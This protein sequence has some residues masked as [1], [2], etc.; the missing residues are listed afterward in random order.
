MAAK[1]Q[2]DFTS[3]SHLLTT[4]LGKILLRWHTLSPVDGSKPVFTPTV[5]HCVVT[6]NHSQLFLLIFFESFPYCVTFVNNEISHLARCLSFSP[7][8]MLQTGWSGVTQSDY[9]TQQ[10]VINRTIHKHA[11]WGK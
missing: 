11:Q 7:C 2:T 8:S 4:C 10:Y 6:R 9:T 1:C 5:L 3:S